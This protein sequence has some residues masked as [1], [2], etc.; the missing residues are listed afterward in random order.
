LYILIF[1]FLD[2]SPLQ[3]PGIRNY[4]FILGGQGVI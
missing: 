4:Q 3:K 1:M 2:K